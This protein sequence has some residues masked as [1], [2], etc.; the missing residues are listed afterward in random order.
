M[1]RSA[2]A[3]AG[4]AL[5]IA[6]LYRCAPSSLTSAIHLSA[7]R[8][9]DLPQRSRR[10]DA[11]TLMMKHATS[12][13]SDKTIHIAGNSIYR[14]LYFGIHSLLVRGID[15]GSFSWTDRESQKSL[16]NKTEVWP[17]KPSC[18]THVN[19]TN[20]TIINTWTQRLHQLT[21]HLNMSFQDYKPDIIL[22]NIGLDHVA[23]GS[24]TEW[25]RALEGDGWAAL[26]RILNNYFQ[27]KTRKMIWSPVYHFNEKLNQNKK[28]NNS[29]VD[30]WN[31]MLYEKIKTEAW[32]TQ[33]WFHWHV[34]QGQS[35]DEALSSNVS[36]VGMD[37]WVHPDTNTTLELLRSILS[38]LC[39]A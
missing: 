17:P 15:N 2:T 38:E 21:M 9:K 32:L 30:L 13:L 28:M 36:R 4:A 27:R 12:C 29:M 1:R 37:D 35:V 14:G 16:C 22:V 24:T 34:K 11:N 6:V 5:L 23:Q 19:E 25:E 33:S 31:K 26:P 7:T 18:T 20:T 8:S 10:A 3:V 39:P